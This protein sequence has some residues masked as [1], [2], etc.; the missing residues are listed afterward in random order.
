VLVMSVIVRMVDQVRL[1]HAAVGAKRRLAE[2][3]MNKASKCLNQDYR[4]SVRRGSASSISTGTA[5]REITFPVWTI[6]FAAT[7]A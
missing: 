6:S 5:D 2:R 7:G 4:R 1:E 3:K